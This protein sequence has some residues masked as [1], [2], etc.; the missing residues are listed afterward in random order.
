MDGGLVLLD[1]DAVA[2]LRLAAPALEF[3][4][5]TVR[6]PPEI[7]AEGELDLDLAELSFAASGFSLGGSVHFDL[8]ASLGGREITRQ[9]FRELAAASRPLVRLGGEWRALSSRSLLRARSVAQ[10]ALHGSALPALTALGAILAGVS[11]VRGLEVAVAEQADGELAELAGRLR[12]PELWEPLDPKDGFQ[13]VL[14]PYQRVGLGWLVRMRELGLGALLADDM[15]LGK[16]V[17]LIAYLIDRRDDDERP[18]LIVAPTSVLGNWEREL[19]R[20]APG[21][22]GVHPSRARPHLQDRRSC[23][24]STW[25][26]PPTRCCRA[27]VSCCAGRAGGRWCWTRRRRSRTRWPGPPRPPAR[28]RPATGWR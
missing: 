14:R 4:G 16:T 28:W 23:R 25:C 12:S 7:A 6:L 5:A 8:H 27:T 9:E 22:R 24:S 10:V 20:F 13:G 2:E 19:H 18:T 26:S 21:L 11:E 3:A 1:T 17:Q 15:G